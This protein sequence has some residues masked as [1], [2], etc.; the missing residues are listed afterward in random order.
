MG[1]IVPRGIFG[2]GCEVSVELDYE[3]RVNMDGADPKSLWLEEIFQDDEG[4]ILN[5]SRILRLFRS[6][7]SLYDICSSDIKLV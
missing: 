4:F 7:A 1:K 6:I 5:R 2:P 3:P